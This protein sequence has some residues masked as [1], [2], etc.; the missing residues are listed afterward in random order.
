MVRTSI[1]E[2]QGLCSKRLA[3]ITPWMQKYLDEGKIPGA[4][5][6]VARHGEIVF[7]KA[8]GCSDTERKKPLEMD[9]IFRFYSMTK[10]VTAVAVLMLYEQGHFQL[11][12]PISNFIPGFKEMHVYKS[13]E[14]S[15]LVT[16]PASGP[17]TIQH[18][19]THTSGLTYGG[20][21]EGLVPELYVQEKTDFGTNDGLLTDVV[22]RLAQ[23][24]IMF[25][26]GTCWNYSVSFDVL[27]RFIEVVSGQSLDV[28]CQE[29]IFEP[30]GMKDT[31]FTVP[32][33]KKDRFTSLYE[34]TE[35]DG[36]KLLENPDHSILIDAEP[37][38][39]GGAGLVSTLKDYFQ[40][41]EMLRLRGRYGD[42]QLLGRKTVEFMT[43]N[44]LPYDL[45]EMGQSTFNET[46][47]EGIGFGCGVSVM[48]NPSKAQILG[49]QGEYGW[50]GYASTVFW[51]DP[52]EDMTVIFLT[53]LIPSSAYGI[54]R[55]LRVLTYQA[56]L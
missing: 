29:N 36:M 2:T 44:H 23:L 28:F 46:T 53:Q 4:M 43:R 37:T 11:D 7:S 15:T 41:T 10:P 50:G 34:Q 40:F 21:N 56:L 49:S 54:R 30:M 33:S 3:R 19:L 5:T 39:S 35:M 1:P 20:G 13:G 24:P 31:G 32:A 25:Q 8:L 17:I 52:Q 47:C 45:A 26:P 18:L 22:D 27:G 38:L 48:V 42:I 6:L 9:S 16:E 14:K 51:T 12:D 55:E